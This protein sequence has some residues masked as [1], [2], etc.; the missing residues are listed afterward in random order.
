VTALVKESKKYDHSFSRPY[1]RGPQPPPRP[2]DHAKANT[3]P[4][5]K[6][7]S[8]LKSQPNEDK[9]AALSAY[10]MSICLCKKCG[11]KWN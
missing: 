7:K 6:T 5:D 1:T 8:G 10:R 9:M 11:E 4:E 3:S 2:P